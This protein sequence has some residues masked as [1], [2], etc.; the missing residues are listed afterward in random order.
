MNATLGNGLTLNRAFD[1]RLRTA[2]ETDT[3]SVVA[4][5]I[6]GA[7]AVTITGAEQSH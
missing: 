2:C 3:G 5:S 6:P 1:S 4:N 7:A